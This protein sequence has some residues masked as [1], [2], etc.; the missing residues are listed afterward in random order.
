METLCRIDHE[1]KSLELE[2]TD[3]GQLRLVLTLQK[4]GVVTK[5]DFFL[6][7]EDARQLAESLSAQAAP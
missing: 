3:D 4:L 6:G 2:R 7:H 1:P 5:L